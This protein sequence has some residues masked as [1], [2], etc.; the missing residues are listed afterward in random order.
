MKQMLLLRAAV[1]KAD[2]L[3]RPSKL[4]LRFWEMG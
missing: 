1:S 2:R 4:S 3:S